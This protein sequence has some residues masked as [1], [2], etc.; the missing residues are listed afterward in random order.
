MGGMNPL[1]PNDVAIQWIKHASKRERDREGADDDMKKHP[2]WSAICQKEREFV[3]Y[4]VNM[5]ETVVPFETWNLAK[6]LAGQLVDKRIMGEVA[7]LLIKQ[8]YKGYLEAVEKDVL[9]TSIVLHILYNQLPDISE[10]LYMMGDDIEWLHDMVWRLYESCACK[11]GTAMHMKE[12]DCAL[13][14]LDTRGNV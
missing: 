3:A 4:G 8:H 11:Y 6:F 10:F 7:Y 14:L 13:W 1:M 2:V 12:L 9:H 5:H